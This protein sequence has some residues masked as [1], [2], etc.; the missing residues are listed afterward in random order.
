MRVKLIAAILAL[1]FSIFSF[2]L[3]DAWAVATNVKVVSAGKPVPKAK[4][5]VTMAD[6]TTTQGTTDSTGQVALNVD[7]QSVRETEV[8]TEDGERRRMAGAWFM[9]AGSMV[10]D[11][12]TMAVVPGAAAAAMAAEPSGWTSTKTRS[13]TNWTF[14]AILFGGGTTALGSGNATT[15][16]NGLGSGSSE[17]DSLT[18]P[19]AGVMLRAHLPRRYTGVLGDVWGFVRY[20]EHFSR[21]ATG[22]R[23]DFHPTNGL[24]SAT[25]FTRNRD[26]EVGVGKSFET[27]CGNDGNCQ[28]IGV[29]VGAS[30]QQNKISM[31]SDESGGG[32]INNHFENQS[33]HTSVVTGA[34]YQIPLGRMGQALDPFSLVLGVDFRR[35]PDMGVDGRSTLGFNY[36]G[37]IDPWEVTT[38]AGLGVAF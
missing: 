20:N 10:L 8:T 35:I 29:Y 34:W 24:D 1:S 18:G 11:T 4:V 27:F 26:V 28:Y 17:L 32:G 30:F 25:T 22:G 7:P 21:G 6:G 9:S 37:Q 19:T 5:K 12:A 23:A 15:T 14:D 36:H 31:H 33:W 13:Q 16:G 38:W 2:I 3:T